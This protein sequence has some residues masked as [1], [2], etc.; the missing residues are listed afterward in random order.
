MLDVQ[1][2]I[3]IASKDRPVFGG[4]S[5]NGKLIRLCVFE[6]GLGTVAAQLHE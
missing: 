2:V 1:T 6:L 3:I 4:D 5:N